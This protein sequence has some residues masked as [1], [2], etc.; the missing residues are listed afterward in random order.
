MSAR[1]VK[2]SAYANLMF[3]FRSPPPGFSSPSAVWYLRRISAMST[4]VGGNFKPMSS[5]ASLMIRDIARLRNH[6]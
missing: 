3:F 2:E 6:L 1:G 4:C 5:I